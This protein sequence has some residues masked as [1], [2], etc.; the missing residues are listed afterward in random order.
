M[1]LQ[2]GHSGPKGILPKGSRCH[3]FKESGLEDH[4]YC[5]FFDLIP[6]QHGL[7][8]AQY[9]I[10]TLWALDMRAQQAS[11]KED[12][13]LIQPAMPTFGKQE[14]SPHRFGKLL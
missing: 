12:L 7:I 2:L 5:I 11:S 8:P 4:I 13:E 10:W 9:G 14:L 1:S 6:A 3:D